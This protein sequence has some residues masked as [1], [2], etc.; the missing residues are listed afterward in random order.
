M[1]YIGE[2]MIKYPGYFTFI[3][4]FIVYILGCT[5]ENICGKKKQKTGNSYNESSTKSSWS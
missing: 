3:I 2:F 1:E 5:I 4:V